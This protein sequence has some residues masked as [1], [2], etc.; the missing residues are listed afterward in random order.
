MNNEKPGQFDIFSVTRLNREVKAVLEGSF[1]SLWVKGEISNLAQPASGHLYFSLKDENSQ[2][3]CAMFRGRNRLLKFQPQN[4]DEVLLQVNINLYEGRGEYQLIVDHMEPA[5]AGALQ[6]A[7]E[8]LK[9]KLNKEGLFSAEHKKPLPGFPKSIGVITSPTG[10]AIRDILNV[11]QRRF[12][13]GDVI[14]YPVP[15]QGDGAAQE[16]HDMLQTCIDRAEVDVVI[17]ARGGGSIEDLWSFN[18][19]KL[20]RLI[21]SCPIP[22]VCGVGHEID[23]T[24][25]DFVSDVRAPT[26]SA[27]AELVCPDS[28]SLKQTITLSENSLCKFMTDRIYELTMKLDYLNTKLAS[29]D[30]QIQPYLSRV[31]IATH[32]LQHAINIHLAKHQNNLQKKHNTISVHNPVNQLKLQVARLKS[33]STA[34]HKYYAQKQEKLNEQVVNLTKALNMMNPLSI[35]T[36]GYSVVKLKDGT[37]AQNISQL[38]KGD[39]ADIILSDGIATAEIVNTEEKTS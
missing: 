27:A 3:R 7:Y 19:E 26:P 4:G 6:R 18:D 20:A 23:F 29:S 36:R 15:V 28:Q 37:V 11:L 22:V 12:S 5:G 16:I 13:L 35:L 21:F 39:N 10:A 14:I 38:H 17:L 25:A 9:Q 1:P 8:E 24:I 30:R 34:L 31:S 2:V 33:A 32:Q